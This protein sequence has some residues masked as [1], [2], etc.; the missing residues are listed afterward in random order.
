MRENV[1]KWVQGPHDV[2]YE[3]YNINGSSTDC[4]DK[5]VV[6]KKVEDKTNN[7]TRYLVK[8][9]TFG[10][11]AGK[12]LNPLGVFYVKGEHCGHRDGREM[13]EFREVPKES[14]Y[15]YI[16]FLQTKNESF[17]RFAERIKT[18]P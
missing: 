15:Q 1:S 8:T 11:G 5:D 14:Y 10:H 6:A 4:D 9:G 7:R 3:C 12:L 18:T 13:Y 17:L 2:V 16:N